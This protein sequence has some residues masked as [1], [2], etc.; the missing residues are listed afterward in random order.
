MTRLRKTPKEQR[1]MRQIPPRVWKP[2]AVRDA[3]MSRL[4]AK[5]AAMSADEVTALWEALKRI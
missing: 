4:Q 3:A 1:I 5:L 2:R